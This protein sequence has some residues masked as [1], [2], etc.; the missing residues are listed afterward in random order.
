MSRTEAQLILN[1]KC[2][3]VSRAFS[4]HAAFRRASA[5]ADEVKKHHRSLM[6]LN[7][8]DRGGSKFLAAKVNAAKELLIS[9][10]GNK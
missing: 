1:V 4:P 8:P 2:V 7:H 10:K 3:A 5:T 6:M 9:G